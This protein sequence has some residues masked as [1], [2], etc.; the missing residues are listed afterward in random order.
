MLAEGSQTKS[1]RKLSKCVKLPRTH[2]KA[3]CAAYRPLL[4]NT[5][6]SPH[7][8]HVKHSTCITFVVVVIGIAVAVVAVVVVDAVA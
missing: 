8:V 7:K 2:C 3:D 4:S 1:A 5:P 6:A